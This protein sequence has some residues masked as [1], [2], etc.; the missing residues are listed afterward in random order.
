MVF[1]PCLAPI[2]KS[3][4]AADRCLFVQ[5]FAVLSACAAG[6][7]Y[8]HLLFVF[9]HFLISKLQKIKVLGRFGLMGD[10]WAIFGLGSK[11]N[12]G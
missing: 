2:S 3:L 10:I 4:V 1:E 11:K 12:F 9:P 7:E 5:L 6:D 8:Y